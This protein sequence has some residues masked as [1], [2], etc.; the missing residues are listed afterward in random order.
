[1]EA[2]LHIFVESPAIILLNNQIYKEQEY[3]FYMP[4][5]MTQLSLQNLHQVGPGYVR[6][7][8]I[9]EH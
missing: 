2:G 5:Q 4:M 3:I 7:C 9:K 6:D 1:M 8:I